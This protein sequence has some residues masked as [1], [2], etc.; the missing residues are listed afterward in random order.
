MLKGLRLGKLI[1]AAIGVWAL[2]KFMG[3]VL[4]VWDDVE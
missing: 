1:K 4:N 3:W 2:N